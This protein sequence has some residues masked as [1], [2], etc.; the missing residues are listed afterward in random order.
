MAEE[1]GKLFSKAWIDR[2]CNALIS[3]LR[4]FL[5]ELCS[6]VCGHDE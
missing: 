1:I 3:A 2:Y 4:L 5:L 6:M